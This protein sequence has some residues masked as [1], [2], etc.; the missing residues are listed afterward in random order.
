M[1]KRLAFGF[2]EWDASDFEAACYQEPLDEVQR[3]LPSVDWAIE[4]TAPLH[5]AILRAG[6]NET[7]EKLIRL[8]LAAKSPVD[9]LA[10]AHAAQFCPM[11][12]DLLPDP[13]V[14]SPQASDHLRA[15]LIALVNRKRHAEIPRLLKLGGSPN[16]PDADG[17]T[18]LHH[19]CR[20]ADLPTF[21]ALQFGPKKLDGHKRTNTGQTP[22][23][24]LEASPFYQR[25][26]IDG[27]VLL[28]ELK[29]I[30]AAR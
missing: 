30:M 2:N 1:T 14:P 19:A 26:P 9:A 23:M 21:R 15:A 13:T 28:N 4:K 5:A 29:K 10:F 17:W 11:V 12:L 20:I 22:L 7:R 18:A 27:D 6:D 3:Q 24:V 25:N 8:L 16:A